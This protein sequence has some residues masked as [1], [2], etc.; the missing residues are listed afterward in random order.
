M[1]FSVAPPEEP[2][3]DANFMMSQ[4]QGIGFAMEEV[5]FD[6]LIAATIGFDSK[7]ESKAE[8]VIPGITRELREE[9]QTRSPYL[10]GV[11][12]SAHL[13]ETMHADDSYMGVVH[14]NP[15]VWHPILGGRPVDYGHRIHTQDGRPWFGW[16]VDEEAER[17]IGKYG[18]QLG[19]VYVDALSN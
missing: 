8:E 18:A 11:L 9:A 12:Q 1:P 14:I 15:E 5:G 19:E 2:P 7:Y 16:T 17:I 13:D 3:W 10:Y 6:E 4:A